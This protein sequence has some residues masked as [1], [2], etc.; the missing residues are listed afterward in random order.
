TGKLPA[1]REVGNGRYRLVRELGRG[2]MGAVWLAQDTMLGREVA[3]KELMVPG[4]V[5]EQDR[6]VYRERVLREARTASQLV[7]PAVVTVHDLINEDGQLY[8]VMELINA[9]TLADLVERDG[10]M[11]G[12]ATATLAGQLLSA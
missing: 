8:I 12:H 1:M 4:G 7:D 2:G 9:P 10:P 3:V 5:P 11:T 6:A